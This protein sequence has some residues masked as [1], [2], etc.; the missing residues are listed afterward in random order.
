MK[1]LVRARAARA[2]FG[3]EVERPFNESKP[4][5]QVRQSLKYVNRRG[6]VYLRWNF[7]PLVRQV[8]YSLFL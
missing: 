4:S 7:S 8:C 3:V 6:Q 5:H 2:T 1:Q